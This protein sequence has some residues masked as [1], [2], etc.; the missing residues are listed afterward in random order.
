[1]ILQQPDQTLQQQA[2]EINPTLE[3]FL[4]DKLN[5]RDA[6]IMR[7]RAVE[8]TLIRHGKLRHETLPRRVR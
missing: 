8:A 3:A 2:I 4:E 7:L 1:M 5:E 6:I